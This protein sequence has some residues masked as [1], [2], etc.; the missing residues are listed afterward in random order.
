MK[1]ILA[2][3]MYII[4]MFVALTIGITTDN[5]PFWRLRVL[6]D[7]VSSRKSHRKTI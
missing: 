5:N 7:D 6:L 3:A 2:S 4:Y 1:Y